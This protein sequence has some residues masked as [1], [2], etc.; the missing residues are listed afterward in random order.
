MGAATFVVPR[1]IPCLLLQ[2]SRLVKTVKFKEPKYIGDPLNAV[3]IF[4]EKEVDELVFLDITASREGRSPEFGLIREIASECF[5]PF[6]YGGGIRAVDQVRQILMSGAEKV[7]LNTAAIESPN[8]IEQA[9]AEFGSQSIVVSINIKRTMFGGYRVYNNCDQ[10]MTS[11]D[12]VKHACDVVKRGSGELFV[13]DVDRDGTREGYD[14]DLIQR[15]ASA[16]DVPVIACGGAGS[17]ADLKAAV[18]QGASAASAGTFFVLYG[19]HRAVLI[20]YPDRAAL[21]LLFG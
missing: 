4:N 8:V 19:K 16:V 17:L 2:Q 15:I 13:N 12:P 20:T 1:I 18:D 3:R 11:L 7:V 6:A 9:S 21:E 14:G 5:M 10:K